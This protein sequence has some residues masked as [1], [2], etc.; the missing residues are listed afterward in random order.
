MNP[1]EVFEMDQDDFVAIKELKEHITNRKKTVNKSK[2]DWLFIRWIRVTQS[3]PLA[4][5]FRCSLNELEAWK[6]VDVKKRARG[7][8]VDMGRL[9]ISPLYSGPRPI[10]KAKMISSLCFL[11][12][13]LPITTSTRISRKQEGCLLTVIMKTRVCR[14][15]K[16]ETARILVIQMRKEDN[17]IEFTAAVLV[18]SQ[19][20][21]HHNLF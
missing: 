16:T 1:F 9:T 8:P 13:H 5:Q 19:P 18:L 6:V 21:N 7:R 17:T 20:S 10:K 15:M 11:L 14:V 3:K 4:F 12:Y 2:V